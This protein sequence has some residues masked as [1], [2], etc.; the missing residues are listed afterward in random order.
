MKALTLFLILLFFTVQKSFCQYFSVSTDDKYLNALFVSDDSTFKKIVDRVYLTGTILEQRNR[1][2]ELD[3]THYVNGIMELP[4]SLKRYSL[5]NK[6]FR[7]VFKGYLAEFFRQDGKQQTSKKDSL[8]SNFAPKERQILYDLNQLNLDEESYNTGSSEGVIVIGADG[9]PRLEYFEV[10]KTKVD[11]SA[12]SD[13]QQIEFKLNYSPLYADIYFIAKKDWDLKYHIA[14]PPD[15]KQVA[16]LIAK[17]NITKASHVKSPLSIDLEEQTYVIVYV[18]SNGHYSFDV[19]QP[20][21]QK[22]LNNV[23]T[24]TLR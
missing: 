17:L 23:K 6:A 9:N 1:Y 15:V 8:I 19:A 16:K 18:Q 12:E 7:I 14:D 3:V 22:P 11:V 10:A 5:V 24:V 2:F 21:T 4:D 13:Y 20:S